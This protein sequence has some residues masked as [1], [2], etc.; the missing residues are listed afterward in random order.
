MGYRH[1]FYKVEK[2]AVEKV[3]DMRFEDLCVYAKNRGV[4][5]YD[6]GGFYFND[7]KFLNK[8]EVFEFGKLY[9]D[10]TA[11]RIYNSGAPLFTNEET[12]KQFADYVP[13]VVGKQGLLTAI[14]IYKEKVIKVYKDMLVDG[15]EYRLPL[16]ITVKKEDVKPIEKIREHIEDKLS[17]IERFDRLV[18]TDETKPYIL[19]NSWQYE[20]TIFNLVHLLKTIDWGKDTILFYGW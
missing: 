13:Y 20:H 15:A 2:S 1:Y 4:E 3:K 11:D 17:W 9:W 7:K 6:E 8:V 14:Q 10:D 16:G 12:Q 18:D 5:I 19:T